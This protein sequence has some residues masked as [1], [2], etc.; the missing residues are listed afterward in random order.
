MT[1]NAKSAYSPKFQPRLCGHN[2]YH[3]VNKKR[4]VAAKAKAA[5][6]T[7]AAHT[8]YAYCSL[9]EFFHFVVSQVLQASGAM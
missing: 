6:A 4:T 7:T 8:G 1:R 2:V 5:A 9:D 3:I